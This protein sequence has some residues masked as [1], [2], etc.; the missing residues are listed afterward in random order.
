MHPAGCSAGP[1]HPER[2]EIGKIQGQA[3]DIFHSEVSFRCRPWGRPRPLGRT[4]PLGRV[5]PESVRTR[6]R[7]DAR[8]GRPLA[9]P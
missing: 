1:Q 6:V 9:R 4:R 7:Q 8:T 5:G 2:L 3:S